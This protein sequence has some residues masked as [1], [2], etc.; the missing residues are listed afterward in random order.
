MGIY[1]SES[2]STTT[3]AR[4]PL[5][6]VSRSSSRSRRGRRSGC[7]RLCAPCARRHTDD[8]R[9]VDGRNRDRARSIGSRRRGRRG[10]ARRRDERLRLGPHRQPRRRRE[11]V[12]DD[13]RL[14]GSAGCA[15]QRRPGAVHADRG[16]ERRDLGAHRQPRLERH[17][18][19][20]N[21]DV[22]EHRGVD[23]HAVSTARDAVSLVAGARASRSGPGRGTDRA[24]ARSEPCACS[25][26]RTGGH[27]C[28]LVVGVE[29]HGVGVR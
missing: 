1:L 13:H 25:G 21:V 19:A 16:D 26:A 5:H 28:A 9:S 11:R 22:L 18:D 2:T 3:G 7:A 10:S 4:H 6:L 12:A 14:Y 15:K 17:R 29:P 20:D 23:C 24:E 27:A 8:A